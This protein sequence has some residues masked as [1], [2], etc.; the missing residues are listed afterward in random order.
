MGGKGSAGQKLNVFDVLSLACLLQMCANMTFKYRR[1]KEPPVSQRLS[2]HNH[3]FLV[4]RT[5]SGEPASPHRLPRYS[6]PLTPL[7]PLSL[8]ALTTPLRTAHRVTTLSLT[9]Y[10]AFP[11]RYYYP[12]PDSLPSSR[13]TGKPSG[14]FPEYSNRDRGTSWESKRT[15]D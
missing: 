10:P 8:T 14:Y 15:G 6:S 9:D 7:T 11:H 1:Q 4:L 2:Y 3:P 13:L 12:A 5:S